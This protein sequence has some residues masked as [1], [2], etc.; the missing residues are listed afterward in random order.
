MTLQDLNIPTLKHSSDQM[1]IMMAQLCFNLHAPSYNDS[2]SCA[3]EK[4]YGDF[5]KLN[6]H[7]SESCM[8]FKLL[9]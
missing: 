5:L 6:L 1:E 3:K 4:S 9:F 8:F 7:K 2:F